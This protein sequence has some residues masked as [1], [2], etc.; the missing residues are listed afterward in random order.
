MKKTEKR[1]AVN[2]KPVYK[3][4]WFWAIV[5]VVII[6]VI[7]MQGE[8]KEQANGGTKVEKVENSADSASKSDDSNSAQKKEFYAVGDT[9]EVGEAAYTLNSVTLVDDRNEFADEQP[10][11][12]IA[13]DY[14]M[15]NN[16]DKDLPV[17]MDLSAY[18]PQDKKMD[19]YPLDNTMGA[20]AAGKAIDCV[21]HFGLNELGEV[22]LQFAPAISLEKT[23]DF[24]VNVQ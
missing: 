5:V 9:V 1:G 21:Q 13:V 2:K 20:V 3:K 4:W 18:D 16:S 14:T 11:Y 24:K 6:A 15:K 10:Q 7:G 19:S 8:E 23:A 22:E 17:G 12:V